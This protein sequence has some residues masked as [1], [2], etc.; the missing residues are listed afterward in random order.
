MMPEILSILMIPW[1]PW[2]WYNPCSPETLIVLIILPLLS[3]PFCLLL[4]ILLWCTCLSDS[5]LCQPVSLEDK[6]RFLSILVSTNF[7]NRSCSG[8]ER[9]VGSTPLVLYQLYA[10]RGTSFLSTIQS[11]GSHSIC[12]K[13]FSV[14]EGLILYK[15]KFT[16]LWSLIFHGSPWTRNREE[17]PP[18]QLDLFGTDPDPHTSKMGYACCL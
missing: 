3:L 13:H 14:F 12:L 2:Y 5:A 16:F 11:K 4:F 18:Y 10:F 8:S 15:W 7:N 6:S 17:A 9:C 1:P